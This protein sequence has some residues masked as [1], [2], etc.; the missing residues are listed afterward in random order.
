MTATMR[1]KYWVV[2]F[3]LLDIG[4]GLSAQEDVPKYLQV[5][6]DV[7]ANVKPENNVYSNKPRYVRFPGDLFSG[8]Q[9]TVRTD[10]TGFV[11]AV[12]DK[13]NNIT[14]NFSTRKYPGLYSIID[15]VDGI[16]RGDMFDKIPH[17][18]DLKAG[19]MLMYK[20]VVWPKG[21]EPW[22]GHIMLVDVTP[23]RIEPQRMPKLEGTVQWEVKVLDSNGGPASLDD[24]RLVGNPER[25]PDFKEWVSKQKTGAGRGTVL[26]FADE[27]GNIVAQSNGFPKSKIWMQ[28]TDR[29]IV[30]ARVRSK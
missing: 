11:E 18:Q 19:D 1:I 25:A 22:N 6:R 14:P 12:L 8:G 10:C 23:K 9:Y 20:F 17:I 3:S 28:D 5:A 15:W 29:R 2:L 4:F 30:M 16:D 13:G 27:E 21:S 26:V 7:V 24:T